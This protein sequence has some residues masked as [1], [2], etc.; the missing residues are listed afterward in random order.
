MQTFSFV[1]SFSYCNSGGEY[2]ALNQYSWIT[3]NYPN[4]DFSQEKLDPPSF[5]HSSYQIFFLFFWSTNIFN[6]AAHGQDYL[7]CILSY[8]D[9]SGLKNGLA[10]LGKS[11]VEID[12]YHFSG[13]RFNSQMRQ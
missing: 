3:I 8:L 9:N 1:R 6:M 2:E 4:Q 5:V 10:L 11:F 13:Y 7:A 12:S